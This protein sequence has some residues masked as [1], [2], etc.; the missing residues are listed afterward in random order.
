MISIPENTKLSEEFINAI[1]FF[2]KLEKDL[3]WPFCESYSDTRRILEKYNV[4][5]NNQYWSK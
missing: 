1:V 2:N 5:F 3:Q 4:D